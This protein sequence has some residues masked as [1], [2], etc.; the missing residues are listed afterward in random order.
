MV[1]YDPVS[2]QYVPYAPTP[3]PFSEPSAANSPLPGAYPG[4]LHQYPLPA[5]CSVCR[6][7]L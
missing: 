4:G 2:G 1:A 5:V 3:T 7:F 6:Y